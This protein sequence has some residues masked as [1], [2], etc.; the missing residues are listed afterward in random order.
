MNFRVPIDP[1][2]GELPFDE[3]LDDGELGRVF[4]VSCPQRLDAVKTIIG[5]E[6]LKPHAFK[7][8][9]PSQLLSVFLS[10]CMDGLQSYNMLKIIVDDA[11]LPGFIKQGELLQCVQNYNLGNDSAFILGIFPRRDLKYS[12]LGAIFDSFISTLRNDN[13]WK[14][15]DSL[16]S[17]R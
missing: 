2:V 8:L 13:P 14:L 3:P 5:E 7:L 15:Y 6:I 11:I 16:R 10:N 12:K 4:R 17:C 1:R 9:F